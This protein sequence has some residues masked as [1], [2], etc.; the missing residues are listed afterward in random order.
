M[1]SPAELV[2]SAGR[3]A[4]VDQR[5]YLSTAYWRRVKLK[6]PDEFPVRRCVDERVPSATSLRT[7]DRDTSSPTDS[8]LVSLIGIRWT[9]RTDVSIT[10]ASETSTVV[11]WRVQAP[12]QSSVTSFRRS[13]PRVVVLFRCWSPGGYRSAATFP[14]GDDAPRRQSAHDEGASGGRVSRRRAALTWSMRDVS[15]RES[16]AL[17]RAHAADMVR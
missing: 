10:S 12:S 9:K 14:C 8:S 5:R 3:P 15:A 4:G 2:A 11:F 17:P 16:S 13:N 1:S 6:S 7:S